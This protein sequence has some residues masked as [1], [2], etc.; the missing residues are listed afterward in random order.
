MARPG[1][2]LSCTMP[3]RCLASIVDDD[4]WIR[5]AQSAGMTRLTS[6]GAPDFRWS[7]ANATWSADG[8]RIALAKMDEREVYRVPVIDWLTPQRTIDWIPYPTAGGAL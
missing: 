4:L 5:D 6:D 1:S 8:R 3:I 2:T 7:V